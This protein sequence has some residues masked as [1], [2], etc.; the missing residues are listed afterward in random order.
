[1]F[2]DI[3]I[4]YFFFEG[5]LPKSPVCSFPLNAARVLFCKADPREIPALD[6]FA[7]VFYAQQR[8]EGT[9][10]YELFASVLTRGDHKFH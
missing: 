3:I 7:R 8:L 5:G 1:M 4:I 6:G 2:V 10:T 9:Q